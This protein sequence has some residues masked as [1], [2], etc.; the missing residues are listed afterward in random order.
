MGFIIILSLLLKLKYSFKKS[1][2]N[3][4]GNDQYISGLF[5]FNSN[6]PLIKNKDDKTNLLKPKMSLKINPGHSKDLSKNDYKLN[7]NNIFNLDRIS[8]NNTLESGISLAYGL[9]Y[10][11]TNNN[12]N[13]DF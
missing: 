7:A 11:L 13:K 3:K 1:K 8:S 6:L 5:Q 10:I 2:T 12:N 4:E 9:D